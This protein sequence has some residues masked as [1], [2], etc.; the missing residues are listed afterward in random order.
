MTDRPPFIVNWRDVQE[1]DDSCYPGDNELLSIGAP[2][3]RITGLTR[4]GVHIE[5]L[6]PG[7]RTCYPH[8]ERDEEEFIFV[9]EGHPDLWIDGVL[10]PLKP[11]DFVGFPA[12]TGIAHNVLNNG[13]DPVLLLVGGERK[14]DAG[15]HYPLNAERNAAIGARW[16]ADAPTVLKG[17]H[18]GKARRTAP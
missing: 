2:V 6:L 8:A 18:D 9:L 4:M 16:W 10:H 11:G 15:V 13:A 14:T 7:R 17:P 3:G 5:T 1:A 12:G